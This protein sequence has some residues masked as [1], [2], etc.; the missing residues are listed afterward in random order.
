[1]TYNPQI[2]K[3]KDI[4]AN[5]QLDMLTNFTQLNDIYGVNGDHVAF[6]ASANRGKHNKV[7]F[8]SQ[9]SDPEHRS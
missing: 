8:L 1:M 3:A 7:T 2:P 5:S 6:N 9:G 4:M